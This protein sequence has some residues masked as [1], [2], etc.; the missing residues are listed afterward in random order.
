MGP[1]DW[2][3]AFRLDLWV[4]QLTFTEW[5]RGTPRIKRA[6]AYRAYIR[7]WNDGVEAVLLP[8]ITINVMGGYNE[9]R[10]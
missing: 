1:W 8:A 5:R 10:A 3:S 7:A 4:S 2:R 9:P 6:Q